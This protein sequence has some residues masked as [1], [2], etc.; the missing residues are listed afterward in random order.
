M[1][2]RML[3]VT[4]GLAAPLVCGIAILLAPEES[5]RYVQVDDVSAHRAEWTGPSLAVHGF[6]ASSLS[7]D[8]QWQFQLR[9]RASAIDVRYQGIVPS[10]FVDGAEVVVAGRLR[11]GDGLTAQTVMVKTP[12]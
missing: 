4:L 9:G 12:F 3:R 7:R 5:P 1:R 6:V 10:T 11:P 2:G 8:G